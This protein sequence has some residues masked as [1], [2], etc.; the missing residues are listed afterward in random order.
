[1]TGSTEDTGDRQSPPDPESSPTYSSESDSD[2]E[3]LYGQD[4]TV[5]VS[6]YWSRAHTYWLSQ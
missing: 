2:P 4:A 6:S 1:M 5:Y 3:D